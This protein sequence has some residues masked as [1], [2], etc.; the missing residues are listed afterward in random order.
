[1]HCAADFRLRCR[2]CDRLFLNYPDN[3]QTEPTLLSTGGVQ[4]RLCVTEFEFCIAIGLSLAVQQVSRVVLDVANIF[5]HLECC[6]LV[7]WKRS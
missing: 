2:D 3:G 1:M 7:S 6:H 5:A 4:L